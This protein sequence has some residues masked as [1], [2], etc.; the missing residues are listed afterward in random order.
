MPYL[1]KSSE[2]LNIQFEDMIYEYDK[3]IKKIMNFLDLKNH[4][5]PQSIFNPIFSMSNTYLI[6]L[7]PDYAEDIKYIENEL[8]EYLYPFENYHNEKK[9]IGKMFLGK[10][11]LNR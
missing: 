10:S 5:R 11:P 2:I 1:E 8:P 4:S 9:S 6:D 7:Y 3:T